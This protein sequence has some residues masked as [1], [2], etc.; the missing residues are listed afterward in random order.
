MAWIIPQLWNHSGYLNAYTSF[1]GQKSQNTLGRCTRNS[2]SKNLLLTGVPFLILGRKLFNSQRSIDR[3]TGEKRKQK[4]A[5]EILYTIFSFHPWPLC[6][7]CH[8][9][10]ANPKG[11]IHIW[12]G[13]DTDLGILYDIRHNNSI[14]A[15]LKM[16]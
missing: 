16:V 9:W 7:Y 3:T 4:D 11:Q 12:M 10:L 15:T 8:L 14:S 5:E 1:L 13:H 2:R 6:Y